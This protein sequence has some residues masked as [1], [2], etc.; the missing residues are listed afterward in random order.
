MRF[1]S[2]FI[3][4]TL[5]SLV[6]LGIIVFMM[7]FF[8]FA[9]AATSEQAPRVRSGSVLVVPLGGTIPELVSDDPFTQSFG[10][11][12][13]YDLLDL[14]EAFYKAA[15]DPRIEGIWLQMK[16]M[17][18]GWGTLEELREALL[19]FKESGKFII[20]SS[21]DRYI[22]EG[23]FFLASAADSIYASAQAPIE[24]NGFY[25][26]AEFYKTLLDNL[27]IEAQPVRAGAYKS[28]VEPYLRTS[29]SPENYEQLKGLLDDR[30]DVFINAIASGRGLQA[31]DVRMAMENELILTATDA[32]REGL[33]TNL[34]FHDQVTDVVR[35]LMSLEEGDDLRQVSIRSYVNVPASEAGLPRGNEGDIAV[36]YAVGTI[37]SGKS[38]YSMN[39]LLGGDIVGSETFADAMRDAA[40]SDRVKAVVVRINSPGGSAA[41]SDAMW[42]EISKTSDIKPVII[43]MGNVA[44]SGGY[45]IATAGDKIVANNLT[46][47]GSIGV[48][49]MMLDTSGFFE[50]KI[51]INYDV[52]RTGPYADMYSGTRGLSPEE[53]RL[54]EKSTDETYETFLQ[55]VAESRGM[56]PEAVN[57][58]AQ[59]RV[60]TGIDAMNVGLVDELGTLTDAIEIAAEEA[61]LNEGSYGIRLLPRPKTMLEQLEEAIE[62]RAQRA[63]LSLSLS[64][65]EQ[66]F[67]EEKNKI[68]E[69]LELN[70]TIQALWPMRLTIE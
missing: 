6:A 23:A 36:V 55:L 41:A 56:T 4:S 35:E 61:V 25:M 51:G 30:Y 34:Y 29:L 13:A 42:R 7:F 43:S 39:P 69:I 2:T 65:T 60:W 1:L 67:L 33:L 31:E 37:M 57:K 20:A 62:A 24:F 27:D 8:M 66:L 58:L 19:E 9:I 17:S 59:G 10:G 52:I 26:A 28:A 53:I 3:A 45:W 54:L 64:P 16:P 14:K 49:S 44:A 18:T 48:Y 32:Y 21:D 38:G 5:G 68:N 50:N 46:I 22:G 40:E 11:G 47:T 63:W 15:V 12:E 70:G